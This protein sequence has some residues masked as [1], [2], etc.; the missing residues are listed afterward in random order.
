MNQ[1]AKTKREFPYVTL[2]L[3]VTLVLVVAILGYTFVDS[4]GLIGRLD[5]AAK[6]NNYKI[7]ENQLDVYRYH[8]AQNQLYTEFMYYQYGLMQDTTGVSKLFSSAADYANYML[9]NYVGSGSF[10]ATAYSYAEQY[11][12]YCEGAAKAG[13]YN[14]YKEEIAADVNSYI[15]GLKETAKVNGV[16][17]NNYLKRW[18][19]NGVSKG[20]VEKAMEYYY[21]GIKYAEKVQKDYSDAATL[22]EIEKYRDEHKSSFYT[23]KYTSYKLVNNDMK[24]AIDA[25]KTDAE[26]KTAIVNY[27][28]NQ[29]FADLYKTNITDKKILDE[30]GQDKTK[31]DVLTTVLALNE[32]GDAEAVFTSNQTSDY[33]KA[34]YTIAN[35]I[36]TSAKTEVAKVTESSSAYAD[37]TG[38][39]L[40]DLQKWLF[41][42]GRKAGDYTVIKTETKSTDK[43]TGKETV[44]TSYTWYV[45][46]ETMVLNTEKTKDA[47]YILLSDDDATKVANPLTATQ[48]AEEMIKAL[49]E[50]KTP[51]KFAELVA[52]YSAGSSSDIH[53][54]ISHDTIKTSSEEMAT[55]LYA[56]GRKEGDI[57]KF[58]V[59]KD[60]KD[61]EKIT[62][63]YVAYFVEENEETWIVNGRSSVA[64]EKVQDWYDKAV[65][66]FNVTIDYEPET[67]AATTTTAA[68]SATTTATTPA[69]TEPETNAESDTTAES[70]SNDETEAGT[71]A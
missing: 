52:K 33:E 39:S 67:T 37:P 31:A 14:Q 24:E 8:V 45:V 7:N 16:S 42:E 57:E 22:E 41:G 13:L 4:I 70:E 17:F 3:V 40:T 27:Y 38:T 56:E 6:S 30:A 62:G 71:A 49:T 28:V 44:T 23:S 12:T 46:N 34:A 21:I 11:L 15:E 20:D 35:T 1:K 60:S 64:N 9:P 50:T 29:K 26:V 58:A 18:I 5:N 43:T 65:I 48:K 2:I 55:W 53:E 47:Y 54:N 68:T 36:H 61:P 66:E 63:Y 10:D 69:D 25:C 32:I 19:G 59:K 51:E